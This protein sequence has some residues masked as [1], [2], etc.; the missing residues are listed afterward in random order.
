MPVIDILL[1][2]GIG[3]LIGN[4]SPAYLI[5]KR[6]GYD[7]RKE[8][9][10]N[11]GATNTLL[12]AGKYAF[13]LTVLLDIL[14]AFLACRLCRALFPELSVAEQLGGVFCVLGHMFPVVLHFHGGKG[15]ASLGGIVLSW[16]LKWFLIMLTAAFAIALV[17][18]YVCFVAPSMSV[19]FPVTYYIFTLKLAAMLVLLIPAVPI[20]LKHRENVRRIFTGTEVRINYLW[21]K[22]GEK[23]RIAENTARLAASVSG[24]DKAAS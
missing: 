16:S 4:F 8:G 22:E 6:R 19:I 7:V 17:T 24:S 11:A 3:Y 10:H 13:F 9:S 20:F 18:R 21:D 1:C 15:L 23:K 5:G 2:C 12:L 14:K